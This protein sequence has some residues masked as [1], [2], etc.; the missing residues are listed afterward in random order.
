VFRN[1]KIPHAH[2]HRFRDTFAVELLLAGVTIEHVSVLLGHSSMKI[3]EKHYSP[4][5]KTRQEK[6]EEEVQKSWGQLKPQL[7]KRSS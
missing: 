3:T 7:V 6:L 1:A 5:V 2:P 4:W